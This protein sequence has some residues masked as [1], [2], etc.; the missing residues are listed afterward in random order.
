MDVHPHAKQASAK[1][2]GVPP[3]QEQLAEFGAQ[4]WRD[5]ANYFDEMLAA[6][7]LLLAF[8]VLAAAL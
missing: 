7:V 3:W 2:I 4:L 5:R 6:A 1:V 8:G